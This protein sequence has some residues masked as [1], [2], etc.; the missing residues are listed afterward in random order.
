MWR[1]ESGAD[2]VIVTLNIFVLSKCSGYTSVGT[3]VSCLLLSC[4]NIIQCN[5]NKADTL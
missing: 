3:V 1:D 4:S 5:L 2:F